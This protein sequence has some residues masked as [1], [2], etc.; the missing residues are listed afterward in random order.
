MEGISF[1]SAQLFLLALRGI[2]CLILPF[3]GYA[4]LRRKHGTSIYPM[5]VGLLTYVLILVP[6]E[7][8]RR[9]LLPG[10]DS[11]TGKWLTV[12]FVGGCFEEIGRYVAMKHAMPNHDTTADALCY[13]CGHGGAEVFSNAVMTFVMLF[14][15]CTLTGTH[16]EALAQQ[17]ILT[18]FVQFLANAEN[19]VFHMAMSVFI[20]RAVRYDDKKLIPVAVFVHMLAN[21]TDF[22]FGLAGGILLTAVICMLVYLHGRI[23]QGDSD[24]DMEY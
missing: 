5:L 10:A 24:D 20:S 21:F 22:C 1:T 7:V 16:L 3:A 19:L 2:I 18:V 12:W 9:M 4:Y 15:A 11:L 14:E 6:R 23:L 17:G 8:V 13:G